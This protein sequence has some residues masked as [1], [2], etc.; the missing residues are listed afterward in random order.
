[1]T[2]TLER[3]AGFPDFDQDSVRMCTGRRSM[4]T[5]A[6]LTG[7]LAAVDERHLEDMKVVSE[8]LARQTSFAFASTN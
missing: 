3:S 7:V 6:W 2:T 5:N 4:T 1:M 8:G